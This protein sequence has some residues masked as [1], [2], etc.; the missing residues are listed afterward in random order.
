MMQRRSIGA[1]TATI[2][3]VAACEFPV[4]TD[5]R[6]ALVPL[7]ATTVPS[8]E[9]AIDVAVEVCEVDGFTSAVFRP[10]ESCDVSFWVGMP[11]L[12]R[13]GH[14]GDG[15]RWVI[16]RMCA[17][18]QSARVEV[19]DDRSLVDIAHALLRGDVC[20]GDPARVMF[21]PGPSNSR[22]PLGSPHAGVT[23]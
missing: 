16:A 10:T 21:I 1:L 11:V 13:Y 8:S 23:P 6:E 7:P 19:F 18:A 15:A 14:E 9:A 3:L 17:A 2:F 5:Q 20:P 4:M 22:T 12:D